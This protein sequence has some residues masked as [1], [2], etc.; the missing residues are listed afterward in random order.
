MHLM[1]ATMSICNKNALCARRTTNSVL[2]Y[3]KLKD[4]FWSI[5]NILAVYS[6]SKNRTYLVPFGSYMSGSPTPSR[7]QNNPLYV[8]SHIPV[9]RYLE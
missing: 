8:L 9:P 6:S 3:L 2:R 5:K 7:Y 4:F 1:A